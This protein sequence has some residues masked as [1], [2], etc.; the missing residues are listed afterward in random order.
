M[1]YGEMV[2]RLHAFL[3]AALDGGVW[4]DLRPG[5]HRIGDWVGSRYGLDAVVKRKN[6]YSCK[7]SKPSHYTD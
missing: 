3:T 6:P 5:I 2:V 4:S 7:K 1:K